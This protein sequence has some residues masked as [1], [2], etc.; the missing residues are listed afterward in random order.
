MNLGGN[1]TGGFLMVPSGPYAR[2]MGWVLRADHLV[3]NW[4]NLT[5]YEVG[6]VMDPNSTYLAAGNDPAIQG[7]RRFGPSIATS[8]TDQ[9]ASNLLVTGP[10]MGP[11]RFSSQTSAVDIGSSGNRY[12]YAGAESSPTLTDTRD[13][14][15]RVVFE[16]PLDAVQGEMKDARISLEGNLSI[17]VWQATVQ[18][19][20]A[21]ASHTFESGTGD[22]PLIP[23]NPTPLVRERVYRLLRL[24]ALN[25]T[26]TLQVDDGGAL[27]GAN[28]LVVRAT[29]LAGFQGTNGVLTR[30]SHSFALAHEP[31]Q[32]HGTFDIF[33]SK[34]APP[35]SVLHA[36]VRL[37]DGRFDIAGPRDLVP[38]TTATPTK[39]WRTHPLVWAAGFLVVAVPVVMMARH[40]S[41]AIDDVEWAILQGH[42]RRSARLARRLIRK[43][44]TDPDAVF[45]Y[46]AT[47]LLHHPGP[48]T[49][50]RVEGLA[51]A[52]PHAARTGIA[53]T[54]T[55]ASQAVGE[56][57]RVRR[58]AREAARDPLLRQ[59]LEADGVLPRSG[60]GPRA[61]PATSAQT[62]YA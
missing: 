57:A 10:D 45:L 30:E 4:T 6:R 20:A 53:Y 28:D 56:S 29:G 24:D 58:W 61:R 22:Q 55:L 36:T 44:P 13:S 18:V 49:F 2:S 39:P 7:E 50:A 12:W 15:V 43:T 5:R 3:V 26:F 46:G 19:R 14:P 62:G 38:A 33:L 47:H 25:A 51:A 48:R 23:T 52:L 32:A 54:L 21:A 40:R 31:F 17:L 35:A 34:T 9:A 1:E 41:V 27:V 37:E 60:K 16:V 59:R 42:S 11:V 8:H